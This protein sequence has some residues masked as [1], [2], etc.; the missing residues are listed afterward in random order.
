MLT[1]FRSLRAT[2][3][4]SHNGMADFQRQRSI[5]TRLQR[6]STMRLVMRHTCAP[7]FPKSIAGSGCIQTSITEVREQGLGFGLLDEIR[8]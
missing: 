6:L 3:R 8:F 1:T 2:H 4:S 5:G 7:S